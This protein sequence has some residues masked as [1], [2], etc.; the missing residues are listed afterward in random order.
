MSAESPRG[1]CGE[2]RAA[3]LLKTPQQTSAPP[4]VDGGLYAWCEYLASLLTT[5]EFAAMRADATW[6]HHVKVALVWFLNATPSNAGELDRLANL[7]LE[8]LDLPQPGSSVERLRARRAEVTRFGLQH[9]GRQAT[10]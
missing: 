9:A 4:A 10:G 2:L 7:A 6:K 3:E 5:A 8:D 1:E